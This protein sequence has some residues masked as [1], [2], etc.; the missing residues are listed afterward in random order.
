MRYMGDATPIIPNL[1]NLLPPGILPPSA[2]GAAPTPL[3]AGAPLDP[4]AKAQLL[5]LAPQIPD[6]QAQDMQDFVDA[7][8]LGKRTK[9][10]RIGLGLGVGL[11]AG[12]LI[13]KLA[14][15]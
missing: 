6:A 1:P 12:L 3:P 4:A 5:A 8:N 7:T 14:F 2:P 10:M 9:L 11:A 13:G 15:K